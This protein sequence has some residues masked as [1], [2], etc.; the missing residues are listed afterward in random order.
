MT[1][2]TAGLAA[3]GALLLWL[4]ARHTLAAYLADIAPDKALWL[5]PDQPEALL[6]LADAEINR[7]R[8]PATPEAAAAGSS[9]NSFAKWSHAAGRL[10]ERSLLAGVEGEAAATA[11]AP[12]DAETVARNRARAERALRTDP[13][14]AKAL[15]IL[16][17]LADAEGDKA[18][19]HKL[20]EA[21]VRRSL[22]ES[23]AAYWLLEESTAAGD[24]ANVIRY[25]DILLRTRSKAFKLVVPHLAS[26]AETEEGAKSLLETLAQAP[27]WRAKFL[28]ALP[29]AVSDARTPLSLLLAL[30]NSASPPQASELA[31]YLRFLINRKFFDLAYYTWLQS[32]PPERLGQTGYLYNGSFEE[33]PSGLPFDWIIKAGAGVSAGIVPNPDRQGQS[34]LQIDFEQGRV[35][36]GGVSE[37]LVLPPGQYRLTGSYKGRVIGKRGL[38]WRLWCANKPGLKLGETELQVGVSKDWQA[39]ALA[40][41]VPETDCP[42]QYVR[43]DLDARSQSERLVSGTMLYDDIAI[44]RADDG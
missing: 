7:R 5:N 29:E 3:F 41:T 1:V 40:F 4:I 18:Q 17:Q 13:L 38:V 33:T 39:F 26:A 24:Y 6:N 31:P 27:P 44:S 16:G 11:A 9:D 25:G 10:A 21:A 34:A 32:L 23:V 30:K 28:A 22:R 12:L 43:L 14:N 36:F 37:L 20:M 2:K 19:A 35:D 8:A 15:R 42:A